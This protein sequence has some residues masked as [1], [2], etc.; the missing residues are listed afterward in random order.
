MR[1]TRARASFPLRAL[2]VVLGLITGSCA[3]TLG[4]L[5][6]LFVYRS[7]GS[8]WTYL[9]PGFWIPGSLALFFGISGFRLL[10]GRGASVGDGLLSPAGYRA[11]GG[12]LLFFGFLVVG[13]MAPGEPTRALLVGLAFLALAVACFAVASRRARRVGRARSLTSA[14]AAVAGRAPARLR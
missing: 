1:R 9:S 14:E 7:P 4:V 3:V 8:L 12:L 2:Q 11:F 13:G 10:A 6:A 5:L